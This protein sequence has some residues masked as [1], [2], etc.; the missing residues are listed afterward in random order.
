MMINLNFENDT[1]DELSREH[2]FTTDHA[3]SREEELFKVTGASG[4]TYRLDEGS[5]GG[6]CV[7]RPPPRNDDRGRAGR[8][9]K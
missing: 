8:L 9:G 4:R 3:R 6:T 7:P 5:S 2:L 1:S